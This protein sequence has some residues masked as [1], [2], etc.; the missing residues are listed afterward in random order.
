VSLIADD[1]GE[2]HSGLVTGTWRHWRADRW[3]D[4]NWNR[5]TTHLSVFS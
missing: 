1:R 3:Y 4:I 2:G 5:K